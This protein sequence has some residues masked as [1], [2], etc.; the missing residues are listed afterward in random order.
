[1]PR[2]QRKT[3]ER[4]KESPEEIFC[5]RSQIDLPEKDKVNVFSRKNRLTP[6]ENFTGRLV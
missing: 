2:H 6:V 4:I 3:I 5:S 1:M